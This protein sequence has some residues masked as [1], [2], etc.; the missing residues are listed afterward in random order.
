MGHDSPK[1]TRSGVMA[2]LAR[3]R[4]SVQ[5]PSVLV[6][7]LMGLA[8]RSS[9]TARLTRTPRGARPAAHTAPFRARRPRRV[10]ALVELLQIHPRVEGRNL[11]GVAVEHERLAPA[12]LADPPLGGLAPPGMI[13]RRVHVGVE[14]V[15]LGGRLVPGRLGLVGGEADAHDGL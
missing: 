2:R 1:T 10:T 15:L 6:T 14:A 4:R 13:H 11:I 7:K 3:S 5:S 8:V 12:E 9:C